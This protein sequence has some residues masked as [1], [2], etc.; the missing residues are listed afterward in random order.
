MADASDEQ[1]KLMLPAEAL[2]S[3]RLPACS[4][5][6]KIDSLQ[7][8]ILPSTPCHSCQT[9]VITPLDRATTSWRTQVCPNAPRRREVVTPLSVSGGSTSSSRVAVTRLRLGSDDSWCLRPGL[10]VLGSATPLSVRATPC[11]VPSTAWRT[12]ECPGA[13]SRRDG[14]CLD[15]AS[16]GSTPLARRGM[17][18]VTLWPS[19]C[20]S[21][22]H[23]AGYNADY[24][25]SGSFSLQQGRSLFKGSDTPTSGSR[26]SVSSPASTV[27]KRGCLIGTPICAGGGVNG[28]VTS[29]AREANSPFYTDVTPIAFA[30]DNSQTEAS[31][32]SVLGSSESSSAHIDDRAVPTPP[33]ASIKVSQAGVSSGKGKIV[34]DDSFGSSDEEPPLWFREI[35]A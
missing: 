28:R 14:F 35:G 13:P 20:A 24:R 6:A 31:L 26:S 1:L 8:L 4:R 23:S 29:T 15:I 3:S 5:I 27:L 11:N 12:Q 22:P 17:R 18:H 10:L 25:Y 32:R 16:A 30:V 9:P 7:P 33:S 2:Q 34:Q 19:S 21:T